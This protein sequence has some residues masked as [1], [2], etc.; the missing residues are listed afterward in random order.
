MWLPSR[1][2]Q[3][4]IERAKT[5]DARDQEHHPQYQQDNSRAP[6]N[7]PRKI[8][9][10]KDRSQRHTDHPIQCAHIFIKLHFLT[11]F[12]SQPTN[13]FD[14]FE[15]SSLTDKYREENETPRARE[16]PF[17]SRILLIRNRFPKR[18]GP[19]RK[20]KIWQIGRIQKQIRFQIQVLV[21]RR[22][23]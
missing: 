6:G 22:S 10:R 5:H 4:T 3:G 15:P 7:R 23:K 11:N 2:P 12:L 17:V 19:I 9:P 18:L 1:K 14:T 21:R 8:Q 20:L 13:E 16:L